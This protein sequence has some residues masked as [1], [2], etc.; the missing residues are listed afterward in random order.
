[1]HWEHGDVGGGRRGCSIVWFV[2]APPTHVFAIMADAWPR[3][4]D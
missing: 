2:V 1:M 3:P 4:Y